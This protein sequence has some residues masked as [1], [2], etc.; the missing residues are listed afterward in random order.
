MFP[1]CSEGSSGAVVCDS[2]GSEPSITIQQ[3][4]DGLRSP[5][6]RQR[7]RVLQ[8]AVLRAWVLLFMC[9][10]LWGTVQSEVKVCGLQGG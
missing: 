5:P 10:L 7:M 4:G 8:A 9:F 6:Y 1:R 2:R 3:A